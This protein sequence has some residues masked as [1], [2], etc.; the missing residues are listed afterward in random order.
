MGPSSGGDFRTSTGA[1]DFQNLGV[2]PGLGPNPGASS[3]RAELRASIRHPAPCRSSGFTRCLCAR[4]ARHLDVGE[5]IVFAIISGPSELV[6]KV[7]SLRRQSV[8]AV[9]CLVDALTLLFVRDM[10]KEATAA[11]R[12]AHEGLAERTERDDFVVGHV[13][14]SGLAGQAVLEPATTRLTA[15]RALPTELQSNGLFRHC[16]I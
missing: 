12:V 3:E 1:P 7:S 4:K 14:F 5:V 9:F 8:A 10:S 2:K 6:I 13:S 11:C 16:Q 15:A